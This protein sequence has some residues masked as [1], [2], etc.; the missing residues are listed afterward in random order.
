MI[1]TRPEILLSPTLDNP[2][3]YPWQLD[4][5]DFQATYANVRPRPTNVAD[6]K[7][8]FL[9]HQQ[10]RIKGKISNV[11]TRLTRKLE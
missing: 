8:F 4:P 1:Y 11:I 10:L 5:V 6:W 3:N 2:T 9:D 7:H